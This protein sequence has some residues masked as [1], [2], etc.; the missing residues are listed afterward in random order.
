MS[1][2]SA[3]PAADMIASSSAARDRPAASASAADAPASRWLSMTAV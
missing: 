2:T 1:T 3:T